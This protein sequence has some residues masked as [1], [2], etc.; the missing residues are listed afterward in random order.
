LT[1]IRTRYH[2]G[3]KTIGLKERDYLALAKKKQALESAIGRR[4]NWSDFLLCI[5]GLKSVAEEQSIARLARGRR[6]SA[7]PESLSPSSASQLEEI[8]A[9]HVDRAIS[10][11][12]KRS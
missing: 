6:P 7:E 4:L 12:R 10:E 5:A 11:I 9:R 1:T 3:Y 2:Y 8:V